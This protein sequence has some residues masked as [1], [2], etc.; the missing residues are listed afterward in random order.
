M[1]APIPSNIPETADGTDR[2][3]YTDSPKVSSTQRIGL[4]ALDLWRTIQLCVREAAPTRP[5]ALFFVILG[6]YYASLSGYYR[7]VNDGI[8]PDNAAELRK[9]QYDFYFIV[10][11]GVSFVYSTLYAGA[12]MFS[13]LWALV[14]GASALAI[15]Q[16]QHGTVNGTLSRR[17]QAA[18][19]G[20][21]AFVGASV[22]VYVGWSRYSH[23]VVELEAD[24]GYGG[25]AGY[26]SRLWYW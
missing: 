25:R 17:R 2:A 5:A 18:I 21:L 10:G 6:I 11:M 3:T 12:N 22:V 9:A 13:G 4:L 26:G 15:H 7:D 23:R 16:D 19:N 14:G 8:T 20:I 1:Q 24:G